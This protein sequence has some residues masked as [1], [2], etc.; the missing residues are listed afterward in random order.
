VNDDAATLSALFRAL[1]SIGVKPYYLHHPDRAAGTTHF[2]VPLSTGRALAETLR[3]TLSGLAQPTYILDI[4][5]GYGK[6][7]ASDSFITPAPHGDG[8]TLRAPDGSCHNYPA[9]PQTA[10]TRVAPHA[11]K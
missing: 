3:A 10:A 9:D 1:V 8:W 11:A 2:R 5:G 6:V 7:W 4:P